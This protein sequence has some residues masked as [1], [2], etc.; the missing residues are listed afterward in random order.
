[1]LFEREVSR[2]V[3][4]DLSGQVILTVGLPSSGQEKRIVPAPTDLFHEALRHE[5]K[6]GLYLAQSS[7]W[8]QGERLALALLAREIA[9]SLT[10]ANLEHL[11]RCAIT[12]SCVLYFYDTTKNHRRQ[13]C[14]VPTCGHRHKVAAIRKRKSQ[15]R[16]S[17]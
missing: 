1:M 8:L 7:S 3:K 2:V 16:K 11:H 9:H 4:H 6:K 10:E 14:S 13:W 17:R 5:R 15:A 12:T